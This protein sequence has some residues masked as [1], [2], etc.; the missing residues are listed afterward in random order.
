MQEQK[1]ITSNES[2]GGLTTVTSTVTAYD[3]TT[4]N[5]LA[6]LSTMQPSIDDIQSY[7]YSLL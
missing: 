3:P 6:V 4:K 2:K 1:T 7:S 5:L